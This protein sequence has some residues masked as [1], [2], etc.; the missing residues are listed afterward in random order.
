MII[1]HS[2]VVLEDV[3]VGAL[4]RM[5][6]KYIL[7]IQCPCYAT[8]RSET[9][10]GNECLNSTTKK[11]FFTSLCNNMACV[12]HF[13]HVGDGG[14]RSRSRALLTMPKNGGKLCNSN[15]MMEI[16]SCGN[17]K[18]HG[19]TDCLLSEWSSWSYCSATCNGIKERSKSILQY[20]KNSG[21]ECSGALKEVSQCNVAEACTKPLES[22]AILKD[23][24]AG[25]LDNLQ[26]DV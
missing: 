4:L 23:R 13:L 1:Y 15:D 17:E 3:T 5:T 18:C 16:E 2:S 25:P 21:V 11:I 20:P 24:V 9:N 19:V 12:Q 10:L 26:C 14:E 7:I 8:F 6:F 22:K